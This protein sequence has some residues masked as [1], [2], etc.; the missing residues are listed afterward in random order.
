MDAGEDE[1]DEEDEAAV[2]QECLS[3]FASKDYIMEPCISA[4]LKR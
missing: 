1:E 2:Q 4:M 3:N